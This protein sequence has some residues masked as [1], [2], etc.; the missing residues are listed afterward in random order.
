MRRRGKISIQRFAII[1]RNRVVLQ[2]RR[3]KGGAG[4]Y[5]GVRCPYQ[6]KLVYQRTTRVDYLHIY[7][8]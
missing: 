7:D 6:N 1:Y 4:G 3:S 2:N 8:A 5:L